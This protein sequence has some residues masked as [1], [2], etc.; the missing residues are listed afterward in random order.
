MN[1]Y[2]I[3]N[4]DSIFTEG[5]VRQ[6][7]YKL[8]DMPDADKPR[9]KLIVHG[10][11]MLTVVELLAVI[12][13]TGTVKEDVLMMASRIIREYGE[14]SFASF[15]DASKIS[16]KLNIPIIK[17]CQMVASSELG[18]RFFK[19]SGGRNISVR[20][21]KEVS[22]YVRDMHALPKEYLR[23]IYVNNHHQIIHDEVLS[24]G[25][26]DANIVHPREVF[27]PAFEY[28]ASAV[29]LVHNHPSGVI[30]PSQADIDIT[31]QLVGAGKIMGIALIDHVIVGKGKF[32][33][34]PVLYD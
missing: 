6:Y 20:N 19:K 26:I 29:I 17:A 9:E 18:R 1:T 13:N 21:A 4:V 28:G 16:E 32:V 25:T 34:V 11:G 15:D 24:M 30:T 22:L 10:P 31:K 7:I 2:E 5:A 23:G 27:K 14:K 12:L 8:R 33:S 3:K